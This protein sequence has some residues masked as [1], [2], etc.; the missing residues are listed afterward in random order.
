[1]KENKISLCKT[2]KLFVV[3][4]QNFVTKLRIKYTQNVWRKTNIE[5][6]MSLM[7]EA[8]IIDDLKTMAKY[9]YM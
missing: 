6:V 8:K 1:M 9:N 3:L 5:A 4:E 7:E 2:P